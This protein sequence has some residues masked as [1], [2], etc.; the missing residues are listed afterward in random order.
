MFY[1]RDQPPATAGGSDF[2]N[3]DNFLNQTL[4]TAA[5]VD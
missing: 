1:L 5:Q 3:V 2:I 4:T